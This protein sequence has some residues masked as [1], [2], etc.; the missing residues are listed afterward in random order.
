MLDQSRFFS[1]PVLTAVAL[2]L[3]GVAF[4]AEIVVRTDEDTAI[5]RTISSDDQQEIERD[6]T[7]AAK[8][9]EFRAQFPPAPVSVA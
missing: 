5:V 6:V 8:S 9:C 4:A 1:A 2:G 3:A 7:S